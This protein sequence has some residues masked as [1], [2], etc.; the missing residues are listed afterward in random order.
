MLL[1]ARSN[2]TPQAC[3]P[4]ARAL[5]QGLQGDGCIQAVWQLAAPG[6][7]LQKLQQTAAQLPKEMGAACYLARMVGVS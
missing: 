3:N 4:A 1:P 7:L 5:L 2:H 6:G